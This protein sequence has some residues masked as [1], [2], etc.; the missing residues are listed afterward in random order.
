MIACCFLG[1]DLDRNGRPVPDFVAVR[2]NTI[3]HR[4]E[5]TSRPWDIERQQFVTSSAGE[6]PCGG[7]PLYEQTFAFYTA[8]DVDGM[9]IDTRSGDD[10]VHADPEFLIA[11]SEWGI[12]PEDRPQ[13]AMLAALEIHGGDGNDRLFGGA[14]RDTIT[15]G[16]GLDVIRGGAGDDRLD[17]G[18]GQDWI[19]GGANEVPPDRY[20]VTAVAGASATNDHVDFAS[21]VDVDWSNLFRVQPQDVTVTGLSLHFGDE[22]DW[23]V[24]RTPDA[25]KRYGAAQAALLARDMI[26][27]QFVDGGSADAN[28]NPFFTGRTHFLF[29][30]QDTDTGERLAVVPVEQFAGVPDYY[31]LHVVNIGDFAVLGDEL[32][33]DFNYQLSADAEFTLTAKGLRQDD[34]DQRSD[35]TIPFVVT[36]AATLDNQGLAAL[37]VDINDA[38]RR[39][40]FDTLGETRCMEQ[41]LFAGH[42]GNRLGFWTRSGQGIEIT[43]GGLNSQGDPN[44]IATDL[45]FTSGQTSD[46]PAEPMGSYELVFRTRPLNL[47]VR[48]GTGSAPGRVARPRRLAPNMSPRAAP[49]CPQG[50]CSPGSGCSSSS[51]TP[52]LAG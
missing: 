44:S 34:S 1:G 41:E 33:P 15:G 43:F 50:C 49:Q 11:C 21:F 28:S 2:W 14:E 40:G 10:E 4:Y 19:A 18:P 26:D 24:L 27:V 36:R 30:G 51:H 32:S 39:C 38:L 9:V 6:D 45:K 29:A 12:D 52:D 20:E 13:R 31:V 17:G 47:A 48:Q 5:L 7:G 23:Y 3:L 35:L 46:G 42:V 8:F 25:L 22:G 37:I 16:D